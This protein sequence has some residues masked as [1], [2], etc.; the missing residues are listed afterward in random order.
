MLDDILGRP[1]ARSG[2]AVQPCHQVWF[3][4]DYQADAFTAA[5]LM[6][7]EGIRLIEATADHSPLVFAIK[8]HFGVS[9]KAAGIRLSNY[10]KH[11]TVLWGDTLRYDS[12][13]H[14]TVLGDG[15]SNRAAS[16]TGAAEN[17][18]KGPA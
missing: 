2:R 9:E 17:S 4:S 14:V 7:A 3:D 10:Q 15:W 18:F 12:S 5:F 11:K 13:T 1:P 16:E 8:R 6:P